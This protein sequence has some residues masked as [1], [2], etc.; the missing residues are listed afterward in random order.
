M[1][2]IHLS[3]PNFVMV[4]MDNIAF[5]ACNPQRLT[6][7][8]ADWASKFNSAL[9][10]VNMNNLS[11]NP[12]D[13]RFNRF[14]GVT[15]NFPEHKMPIMGMLG[16]SVGSPG[17]VQPLLQQSDFSKRRIK[18]LPSLART[19]TYLRDVDRVSRTAVVTRMPPLRERGA[20]SRGPK[21]GIPKSNAMQAI[22]NASLGT[23]VNPPTEVL[24]PAEL[25]ELFGMHC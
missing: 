6:R 16:N 5:L 15:S 7:V 13:Q 23:L 1:N 21:D 18:D 20:K 3:E 19:G 25:L 22:N 10:Q 2:I 4:C 24:Q 8:K 17:M 9:R 14:R 12:M 11:F